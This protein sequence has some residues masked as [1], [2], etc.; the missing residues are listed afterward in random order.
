MPQMTFRTLDDFD[1][2]GKR[3]LVRVDL[4]VPMKAGKVTDATRIERA[5]PT[6]AELADKGVPLTS[7]LKMAA[8]G[9]RQAWIEDPDGHRIELM[10]LSPDCL[11]LKAIARLRR[12]P[13]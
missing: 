3:V 10:Q 5:A 11:Q 9:N 6:L 1:V 8:D 7:P 12:G 13:A 4:N 2:A